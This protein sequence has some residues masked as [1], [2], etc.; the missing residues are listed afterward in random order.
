MT[1]EERQM[2]HD[3]IDTCDRQYEAAYQ[4]MESPCDSPALAER[5]KA[6]YAK[7]ARHARMLIAETEC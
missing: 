7:V 4:D 1:D 2:L 3:I 6:A 5:R